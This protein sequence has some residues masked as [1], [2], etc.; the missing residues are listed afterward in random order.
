[1]AREECNEFMLRVGCGLSLVE[2][3]VPAGASFLFRTTIVRLLIVAK[4]VT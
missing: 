1:M 3:N 4:K 2:D